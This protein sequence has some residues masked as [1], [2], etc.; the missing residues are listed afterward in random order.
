MDKQDM[1]RLVRQRKAKYSL[2]QLSELSDEICSHIRQDGLWRSADTVL[3]Y[4][5]LS[6][7]VNLGL[8]IA[9][10]FNNGKRVLLPVVV[11]DELELRTFTPS[12]VLCEG[13]FHIMEP[14]GSRFV[15]YANI[16]LAIIPGMAFDAYGHR[17]GRGKGFYDKLL[18][19]I[20]AYRI[21]VCFPFQ[22]MELVPH[23]AHDVVM[24]EVVY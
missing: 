23:E 13:P 4:H 20:A 8:L 1:R 17:L 5:A 22:K 2:D 15:D 6:D 9:D 21:G 19:H 10:A 7:E 12:S 3:L 14:Q 24:N 18:P 16:D 11:G